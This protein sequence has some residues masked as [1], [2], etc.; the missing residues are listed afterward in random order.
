MNPRGISRSTT[1]SPGIGLR[2]ALVIR[3]ILSQEY[4]PRCRLRR[5]VCSSAAAN[6]IF[7]DPNSTLLAQSGDVLGR[8][9]SEEAA[10]FPAE[11]RRAQIS[12]ALACGARVH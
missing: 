11:L 12:H 9:T 1:V 8:R 10:V 6:R 7:S 3:R 5:L 2:L 4:G